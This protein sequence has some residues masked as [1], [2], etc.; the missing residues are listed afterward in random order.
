MVPGLQLADHPA[1]QVGER[2]VEKRSPRL[3]RR[4]WRAGQGTVLGLERLGELTG[5]AFLI[6]VEEVQGEDAAL[7]DQVVRM[8]VLANGDLLR[9]ERDLRDPAGGEP[10]GLAVRANG[11]GDVEAVG[12]GLEDLTSRLLLHALL[13]LYRDLHSPR[14]SFGQ[15]AFYI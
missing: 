11:A 7:F 1:L 6:G 15:M 4:V 8:L 3:S 10:V 5:H 13:L 9:L 12:D 14:P 2:L